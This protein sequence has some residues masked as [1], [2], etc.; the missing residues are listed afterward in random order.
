MEDYK[1]IIADLP[2]SPGVYIY[3]NTNKEIIYIGKAVNL[4]KRV[5]QYFQR[6]DAVGDKTPQLVSEIQSLD[7]I[8][9]SNEFD[10]LLLEAKLIKEYQPKYNVIAKDD[11]S[12]LYVILTLGDELPRVLF[13]RKPKKQ[14]SNTMGENVYF[15]PF[16]SAKT[17]RNLL[18][19]LR[20]VV[21]YCTQKPRNGKKCFYTHLGLCS[22][23]PSYISKLNDPVEKESLTKEYRKN[24]FRLR[25]IM[26]GKAVQ[27]IHEMEID[28]RLLSSEEKFEE[29]ASMRNQIEALRSLLSKRYDPNVYIQSDTLLRELVDKEKSELISVLKRY[30]PQLK[31]VNRIECYDISNTMGT[32]ATASMVVMTNGDIDTNEYRKF[33]MRTKE[34]PNDFAMMNEV[35]KR[36][37]NHPEWEYPSLIVIDGGKG[38]VGAAL[39]GLRSFDT[40]EI[41]SI[42][43]IGLAKK[44]EEIIVPMGED[45][46]TIRLPFSS[47]ALKLLQ[48]LRDE[49]HRFAITYHK[50][51]RKNATIHK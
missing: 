9:T 49:A 2:H 14:F 27:I 12:P 29:A 21:P 46:K 47:S 3:K 16:Q 41:Q 44:L 18:R 38:Q 30:Y 40:T 23:C 31:D 35:I 10:A 50:L 34:A 20:R 7:T 33:R 51:L 13:G 48:R 5:K 43:V 32:Y 39:E 45:W 25:D 19:S 8:E 22:P 28:M 24:I 17:A 11:K 36:R 37:F 15:G 26:S 6:E 4:S 1:K 42:P